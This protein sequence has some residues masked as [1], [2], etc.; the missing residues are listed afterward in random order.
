MKSYV[1]ESKLSPCEP[2]FT[3]EGN[4]KIDKH[5]AQN[6]AIFV[7]LGIFKFGETILGEQNFW[8]KN[9]RFQVGVENNISKKCS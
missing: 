9:I 6:H 8:F 1:R 7:E 3:C 4:V 5:L 2:S